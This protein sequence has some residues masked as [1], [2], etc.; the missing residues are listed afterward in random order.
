MFGMRRRKKTD[1]PVQSVTP[2]QG[3]TLAAGIKSSVD[4]GVLLLVHS[5][6]QGSTPAHKAL[7]ARA[8]ANPP[9]RTNSVLAQGL[10]GRGVAGF[11]HL[12]T[13]QSNISSAAPSFVDPAKGD[14]AWDASSPR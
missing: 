4:P 14:L 7:M 3:A 12:A 6:G 8:M 11:A 9:A 10:A 1:A 2:V 13:P 5:R